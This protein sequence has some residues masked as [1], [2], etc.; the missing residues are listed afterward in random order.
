MDLKELLKKCAAKRPGMNMF[1][2]SSHYLKSYIFWDKTLGTPLKINQR[3][4]GTCR[5]YIQG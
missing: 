2:L 1:N 5:L 4:G 3:F